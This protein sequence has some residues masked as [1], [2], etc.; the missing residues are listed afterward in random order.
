MAYDRRRT[1]QNLAAIMEYI[2]SLD[3]KMDEHADTTRSIEQRLYKL[4]FDYNRYKSFVGGV[5]F[6]VTAIWS[7]IVFAATSGGDFVMKLFHR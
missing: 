1:D 2:E 7:F 4:E 5:I 6:V 3:K